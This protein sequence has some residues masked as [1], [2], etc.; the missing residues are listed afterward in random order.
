MKRITGISFGGN[1]SP[2]FFW[3][4]WMYAMLKNKK[5]R[6]VIYINLIGFGTVFFSFS[7]KIRSSGVYVIFYF[8]YFFITRCS[9]SQFTRNSSNFFIP[10]KQNNYGSMSLENFKFDI[11]DV[12]NTQVLTI[13]PTPEGLLVRFYSQEVLKVWRKFRQTPVSHPWDR[14]ISKSTYFIC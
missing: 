9:E 6:I 11:L 7:L 5:T 13:R 12:T 1:Y 4:I 14:E 3:D 10:H 2:F 8:F